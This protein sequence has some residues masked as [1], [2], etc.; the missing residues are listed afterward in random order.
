[1]VSL[2]LAL[3][4][5]GQAGLPSAPVPYDSL[6]GSPPAPQSSTDRPDLPA[7]GMSGDAWTARVQGRAQAAQARQGPLDGAWVLSGPDGAALY[8][9]QLSDTPAQG[10]EGAWRALGAEGGSGLFDAA[11]RQGA[12]VVFRFATRGGQAS[13]SL[14]PEAEGAWSGSLTQGA[15]ATA[16]RLT[17][18]TD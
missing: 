17:R 9:F 3:M 16:V 8:R 7:R 10:L 18:A 12:A 5:S 13:L 2:F 4:L 14:T 6:R 15:A 1:M 11:E